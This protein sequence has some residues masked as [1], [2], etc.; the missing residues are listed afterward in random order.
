[1]QSA[2]PR[3]A[4]AAGRSRLVT[5]PALPAGQTADLERTSTN[6]YWKE[7]RLAFEIEE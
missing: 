2:P 7:K 1:M 6:T 3:E 5:P 4:D